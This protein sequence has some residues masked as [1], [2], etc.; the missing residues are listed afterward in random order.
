MK[1]ILFF[2]IAI[3]AMVLPCHADTWDGTSSDTSW[4]VEE[5]SE[6]HIKS[7]SQLK[8]FADIVN[9]GIAT[10]EGKTVYLDSDIDLDNNQWTPIGYVGID[11]GGK[12]FYGEFNGQGHS[13]SNMYIDSSKLPWN[14]GVGNAGLFG[15]ATDIIRNIKVDG[16]IIINDNSSYPLYFVGGIVAN[17]F[18]VVNSES[19]VDIELCKSILNS[20]FYIGGIAGNINS[21]SLVKAKGDIKTTSDEKISNGYIGGIVGCCIEIISESSATGSIDL[22][23]YKSASIGGMLSIGGIVGGYSMIENCIFSGSMD[24]NNITTDG[25][26][27]IGGIGGYCINEN[28]LVYNNIM[29]PSYFATNISKYNGQILPVKSSSVSC[30]YNYYLS[31]FD[32]GNEFYGEGVNS[33]FLKSGNPLPNFDTDIW[34]FKEGC[35]P[36]LKKLKSTYTISV[37]VSDGQI[38][39]DVLEGENITIS[40][41]PEAGWKLQTLYVD[42]DDCTYL[43]NGNRYTFENVTSNHTVSAVFAESATGIQNIGTENEK[44]SLKI[45]DRRI[46]LSGVDVNTDVDIYAVDGKLIKKVKAEE[47]LEI[48]FPKGIYIVRVGTDSFK[49][50]L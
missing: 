1:K 24:V 26:V 3:L 33:D 50:N 37:P 27:L 30:F 46:L 20:N 17:G 13:I 12:S 7:A 40:I 6:Y 15:F 25:I 41:K 9:N 4:Y 11:F 35:Y 29:I 5:L 8:G 43:M 48:Q 22:D 23:V 45:N 38:G 28:G 47:L 42:S 49:I 39:V 10:F 2:I 21:V 36:M 34:E 31:D 18:G 44:V 19:S 14:M 32:N 16:L